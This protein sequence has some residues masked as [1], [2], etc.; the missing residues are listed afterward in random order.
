MLEILALI[1]IVAGLLLIVQGL[2]EREV[3]TEED[4][5]DLEEF[6]PKKKVTGGGVVIIGP[7]PIVFGE[8]KYAFYA[9]IL[10]TILTLLL[11]LWLVKFI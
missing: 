1:L 10:A 6:E 5:E 11:L 8:S 2:L 4:F 9:L 3:E 7:I